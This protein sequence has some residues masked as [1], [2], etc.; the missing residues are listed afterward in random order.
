MGLGVVLEAPTAGDITLSAPVNA[1]TTQVLVN[2]P[3]GAIVQGSAG[4]I[5]AGSLS[6][7]GNT[8]I[9]TAAAPMQ[10]NVGTL[11]S[12]GSQGSIYIND[13]VGLTVDSISALG[14]V[15]VNT[16]GSLTIPTMLACDCTRSISGSSVTLTAYG[17]MLLNTGSTI[18]A[19]NG[20][21]LYAGYDV[22]SST[23]VSS[24]G[25][26]TADG[27]VT[28][29]TIDLF[30]AGAINITGSMTGVLTHAAQCCPPSLSARRRPPPLVA[31]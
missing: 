16:G 29:A 1:G 28:G 10:I 11:M 26:L 3:T 22:A 19:A 9:G 23:Y 18:T 7:S 30:A 25:T 4:L 8:G 15:D 17:P 27:S 13:S 24:G 5:T 6:I 2:A 12:A 20:V 31:A 14:A 21:A